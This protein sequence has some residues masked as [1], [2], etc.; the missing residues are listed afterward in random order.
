MF[1]LY[2]LTKE[3]KARQLLSYAQLANLLRYLQPGVLNP[4]AACH[5]CSAATCVIY[6]A[7]HN[8]LRDLKKHD[9]K[10]VGL[11]FTKPVQI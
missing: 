9:R 6:R 3:L 8:V 7:F 10:T 11:L 4:L 5:M 1:F 2:T